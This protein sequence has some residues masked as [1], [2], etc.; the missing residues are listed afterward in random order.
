MAKSRAKW[1]GRRESRMWRERTP[2][3]KKQRRAMPEKRPRLVRKEREKVPDQ[4]FF[5]TSCGEMAACL[6][7][8]PYGE[9]GPEGPQQ[10]RCCGSASCEESHWSS[11]GAAA[12]G[13]SQSRCCGSAAVEGTD[14]QAVCG[15]VG[16]P[17]WSSLLLRNCALGEGL[18]SEGW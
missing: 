17:C 11:C 2:P 6:S 9:S 1:R 7:P 3:E 16:C 13:R 18:R 15:S 4:R 10:S 14:P 8:G 5:S 12:C